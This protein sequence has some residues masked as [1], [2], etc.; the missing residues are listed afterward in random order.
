ML[1][2]VFLLSELECFLAAFHHLSNSRADVFNVDGTLMT[3]KSAGLIALLPVL[4][5]DY[6]F[7]VAVHHQIGIVTRE[8]QL[9][10]RL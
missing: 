6:Q 8:D 5:D 10:T 2:A 3:D 1:E 9:A 4:A 7:G